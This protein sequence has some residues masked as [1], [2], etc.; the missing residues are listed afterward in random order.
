MIE[1]RRPHIMLLEFVAAEDDELLRMVFAQH[2]LD[3]LLAERARP[4]RHQHN[5]FLPVHPLTAPLRVSRIIAEIVG[6]TPMTG[7][8]MHAA[9]SRLM[10]AVIGHAGIAKHLL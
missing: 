5:L 1:S 2:H 7:L 3:E 8:D 10:S 4:A 9:S 6:I